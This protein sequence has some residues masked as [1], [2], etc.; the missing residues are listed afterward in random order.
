[1]A[2]VEDYIRTIP[3]FPHDGILF[4]DVTTLF[5][6]PAGLALAVDQLA[7][8]FAQTQ[9]EVVAGLEARGFVIGGAVAARLGLGFVA[10]R[11][12]GKLPGPRIAED[13]ELEY[14][15]ATLEVH[16]DAV[17]PGARV[18]LIDDLIATGGT[19]VAGIRLIERLGASVVAAGFI[20]DLPDLGGAEVVRRMGVPLSA[21]VEFAG[22]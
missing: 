5:A 18:I 17:E 7:G 16:D 8:A 4:R 19:A 11:K 14:G 20:V 3:D 9:A 22:A 10:L 15:R 6:D 1:M 21:L 13:Y 2:R 12:A